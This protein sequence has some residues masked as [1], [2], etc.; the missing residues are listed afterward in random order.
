MLTKDG[1]KSIKP[2]DACYISCGCNRTPHCLDWGENNLICYGACH[3]IAIYDPKEGGGGRV[4]ITLNGHKD[5]VNSVRW[6]RG[7]TPHN[8]T[9]LVSV[10]ADSTAIVWTLTDGTF[11]PSAKLIDIFN[12]VETFKLS[13]NGV[14]LALGLMLL[15]GHDVPLLACGNDDCKVHLFLGQ[16]KL[17]TL[18]GHEDWVRAVDFTTNDGD[19]LLATGSQDTTVRLWRICKKCETMTDTGEFKQETQSINV[20]DTKWIVSLESI[21]C[22]HEGW[23]YGVHWH[24]KIKTDSG[25]SQPMVL[26]S[27][28]LDRTLV[29]WTPEPESGVWLEDVRVG[30]L[31][32]NTL[33]YYGSRFGPRGIS[34]IGHSFQGA[35]HM[36]H[37]SEDKWS[38]GVVV[39]GHFGGVT[40]MGWETEGRYLIS[41][42]LDQTTRLHAPWINSAS[43][44]EMCR[45]QIHGYD[46]SC[47]AILPKFSFASGSEEKVARVFTA[48]QNSLQNLSVLTKLNTSFYFILESDEMPCGAA[49]PA[50]GLSNK[51]VY[52]EIQEVEDDGPRHTKDEYS[53]VSFTAQHLKEPGSE[54]YLV[55]NSLWPEVMKLYGHGYEVFSLAASNSGDS[56]ASACKATTQEH[57]KIILWNTKTW[58]KF[59]ELF[60]HQLTITQ[61]AFSPNDLCLLSVSRDRRW[62]LFERREDNMYHLTAHSDKTN[63]IHTRIIWTCSWTHDS[64]YF[65]T[66]SREGKL[67]VWG[68][69]DKCNVQLSTREYCAISE[70]L[71]MQ[72][73][74]TAVCFSAVSIFG[75]DVYL[76]AVGNENGSIQCYRWS[77]LEASP[78]RVCY[79]VDQMYPLSTLYFKQCFS[80]IKLSK[81]LHLLWCC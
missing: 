42:S 29:M 63:S 55:Q 21:L 27:S 46:M 41:V 3:S 34:A 78:W 12:N 62:C 35:F 9:E 19:I 39:G 32:G 8:E 31:G 40:D 75:S 5:R 2:N 74:V 28:S 18:V 77:P 23:V 17:I 33:G 37:K 26:L 38:S 16:T 22:G 43:W 57:A 53:D 48:P 67:V 13:S 73:A 70:P 79:Q 72:E 54:D 24:P 59:Q 64:K 76:M 49:V 36:W 6:I 51:A 80:V 61:M 44:H 65:A 50:L 7:K 81:E 10:S 66:G 4:L 60:G 45:P 52:S 25:W 58:D 20:D 14:C 1:A 30:E 68:K 15:P 56:L 47:L 71:Q 69:S 11:I